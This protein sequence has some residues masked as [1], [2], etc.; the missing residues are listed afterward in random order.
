VWVPAPAE[1]GKVVAMRVFLSGASDQQELAERIAAQLRAERHEVCFGLT[2]APTNSSPAEVRRALRRAHSM[3]FL[4]SPRSVAAVAWAWSHEPP[5]PGPAGEVATG[6]A[7]DST[8]DD[9][10]VWLGNSKKVRIDEKTAMLMIKLEGDTFVQLCES[11]RCFGEGG[12]SRVVVGDG[13]LR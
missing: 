11:G 1:R 6:G 10:R 2:A 4:I 12:T 7:K 3:V 5:K 8:K 13:C 9:P